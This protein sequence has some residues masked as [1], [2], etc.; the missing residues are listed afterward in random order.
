MG[1][2]T[3]D[4]A[5]KAARQAKRAAKKAE[6]QAR[7]SARAASGEPTWLQKA[8]PKIFGFLG[9]AAETLGLDDQ[10]KG[11]IQDA[12]VNFTDIPAAE[13]SPKT[14]APSDPV[15]EEEPFMSTDAGRATKVL[16]LGVVAA[17][18]LKATG[19]L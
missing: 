18:L 5:K 16:G 6:R 8:G 17:T 9:N 3:V 13:M 19:V 12:S 14:T 11:V 15:F 4:P 2:F 7:Q 10:V 1:I